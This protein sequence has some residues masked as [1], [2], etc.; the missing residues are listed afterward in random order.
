M[1]SSATDSNT[2]RGALVILCKLSGK[3]SGLGKSEN[4]IKHLW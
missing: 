4:L 1:A 2:V 3:V